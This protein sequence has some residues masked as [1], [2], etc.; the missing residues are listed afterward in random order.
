MDEDIQLSLEEF[1]NQLKPRQVRVFQI[2][3]FAMGFGVVLFFFIVLGMYLG[4]SGKDRQDPP[5]LSLIQILTVVHVF[6]ACIVYA[7][8]FFVYRFVVSKR[9]LLKLLHMTSD[10]DEGRRVFP[11]SRCIGILF[12]GTIIRLALYEGVALFGLIVCL[13]SSIEGVLQQHPVYWLNLFSF[14]FLILYILLTFPTRQRL[15]DIF[16]HR[17][18][19]PDVYQGL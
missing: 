18:G 2:I 14:V 7:T 4:G 5:D 9:Q 3:A 19:D 13:L 6:E 15:E 12:T 1:Q 16:Q 17:F 8:G 11:E 10:L